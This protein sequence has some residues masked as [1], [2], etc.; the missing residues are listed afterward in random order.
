VQGNISALSSQRLKTF[1]MR[2]FD[3]ILLACALASCIFCGR[4]SAQRLELH[5]ERVLADLP[6]HEGFSLG[7]RVHYIITDGSNPAINTRIGR[8]QRWR[9]ENAPLLASAPAAATSPLYAFT[10][11]VSSKNITSAPACALCR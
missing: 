5:R 1:T 2:P 9:V 4:G 3:L 8:A 11:G 6:L 10:N 7:G